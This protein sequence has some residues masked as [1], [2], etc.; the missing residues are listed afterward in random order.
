ME[1]RS[2]K[3]KHKRARA[4][5]ADIIRNAFRRDLVPE[6]LAYQVVVGE[7]HGG[8]VGVSAHACPQESRVA[9]EHLAAPQDVDEEEVRVYLEVEHQQRPVVVQ[10]PQ[11]AVLFDFTREVGRRLGRR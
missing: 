5:A 10:R 6:P 9:I 2:T 4:S 3:K 8:D 7:V 11:P 1:P